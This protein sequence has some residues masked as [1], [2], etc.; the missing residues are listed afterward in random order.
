MWGSHPVNGELINQNEFLRVK[1]GKIMLRWTFAAAV[2]AVSFAA[3]PALSQTAVSVP[4]SFNSEIGCSGDWQPDCAQ[5]QLVLAGPSTW[6]G[7]YSLPTG[8]YEFKIAY[9][10]AWTEN[11][12][13]G[14]I[15]NGPNMSFA[16][17]PGSP[18]YFSYNS[19]TH[20]T[21]VSLT[22]LPTW[23]T[24]AGS[25]Q[26]E[27]GCPGDWD[28]GCAAGFMTM[29]ADGLWYAAFA[30][31]TGSYEFKIAYDQ[32]WDVNYGLGGLINGPNMALTVPDPSTVY[33]RFNETTHLTDFQFSPFA[34]AVPE[35]STWAMMLLGFGAIGVA[36]R[37]RR[38]LPARA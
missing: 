1:G 27:L 37:R 32:S 24:L 38:R 9:D 13:A 12:G 22:P 30:L 10:N 5:A 2:L 26:S 33:F 14:G 7:H 4:G 23:V 16:A 20:L 19:T 3:S 29:G 18:V 34:A 11:Y 21:E 15:A 31:P 35:S 6:R 8:S 36:M 28:P 17:P 25:F